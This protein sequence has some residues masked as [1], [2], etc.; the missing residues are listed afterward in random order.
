MWKRRLGLATFLVS[1]LTG[2]LPQSIK[3]KSVSLFVVAQ[4]QTLYLW[5]ADV[6]AADANIISKLSSLL[7]SPGLAISISLA[8]CGFPLPGQCKPANGYE[9][10]I[11]G[12]WLRI[13][14]LVFGHACLIQIAQITNLGLALLGSC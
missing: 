14:P 4:Y 10:S 6:K 11:R 8:H 2:Q 12:S 3:D 7:F 5:V 1:E 13:T 9:E